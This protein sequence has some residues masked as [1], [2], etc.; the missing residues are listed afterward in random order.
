MCTV[1]PM[2]SK[3]N[4]KIR[5]ICRGAIVLNSALFL[6]LKGPVWGA[7]MAVLEQCFGAR[8]REARKAKGVSQERLALLSGIDRSYMGRIE[9]GEINLTLEKVY[10]IA[11]ALGVEVRD[12]LPLA[13]EVTLRQQKS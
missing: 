10:R 2:S 3:I 7:V 11:Q 4:G 12:L 9:R 5:I 1:S 6:L 8:V 13:D